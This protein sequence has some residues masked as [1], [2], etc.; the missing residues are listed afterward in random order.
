MRRDADIAQLADVRCPF[1]APG[2]GIQ[3]LLARAFE[4][5]NDEVQ[6]RDA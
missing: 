3:I 5:W 2:A 1:D 4:Y 6:R